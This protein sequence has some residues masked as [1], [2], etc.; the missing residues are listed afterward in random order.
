[1]FHHVERPCGSAG[2]DILCFGR[3]WEG[4]YT[5]TFGQPDGYLYQRKP[6]CYRYSEADEEFETPEVSACRLQKGVLEDLKLATRLVICWEISR[7]YT[8]DVNSCGRE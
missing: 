3:Q 5:R 1:M 7:E 6:L 8:Q 2:G 4:C